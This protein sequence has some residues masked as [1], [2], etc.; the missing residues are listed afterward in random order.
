M[1]EREGERRTHDSSR[2]EERL[3]TRCRVEDAQSP[4]LL[5]ALHLDLDLL[6][7]AHDL[8]LD[9]GVDGPAAVEDALALDGAR[10]VD[11]DGGARG[12]RDGGR[13]GERR[14]VGLGEEAVRVLPLAPRGP[15]EVRDA[16]SAP[17]SRLAEAV[18]AGG[19]VCVS[20]ARVE[21]GGEEEEEEEEGDAPQTLPRLRLD[22][23]CIL[24]R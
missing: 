16:Q 13:A 23:Q 20:E 4:P 1:E 12:G 9:L 18:P 7:G 21:E 17:A 11:G 6:D 10:R 22:E 14:E 5:L 2:L 3:D 8:A 19:G 24:E 15:G